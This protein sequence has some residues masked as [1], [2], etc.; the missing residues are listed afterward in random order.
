[1][2]KW[3]GTLQTWLIAKWAQL[4]AVS[5]PDEEESRL[6]R[7]FNILMVVSTGIVIILGSV[8]LL[9]QPLGL[10]SPGVSWLAS[11]FPFAFVPLSIFC[12]RQARR[13][14]IRSSILLYVWINFAGIGL[15]AL[16]F[17]G[18]FSPAWILFIWTIT[19]A[20]ILLAPAYALWMT[21]GVVAYFLL[22][23][24]FSQSGIYAPPL[25]F[26][27]LGR[28]FV[29]MVCVMLMLVSTVGFLTYLNMQ[30][31]RDALGRLRAARRRS[32]AS[33]RLCIFR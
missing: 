32:N 19:I 26:G 14:H 5:L 13:G 3:Y 12:I 25:T 20:G 27:P 16:L 28:E 8:F 21:S 2:T 31:L 4:V 23:L 10:L 33:L 17:D 29:D 30:S 9:M 6:G 22:L 11:A 18:T 7:L 15:A 1:M 24:L